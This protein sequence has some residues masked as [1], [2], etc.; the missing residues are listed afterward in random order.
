MQDLSL[1]HQCL[2]AEKA[3]LRVKPSE[4][5][6][7]INQTLM[8]GR[9]LS[10][11]SSSWHWKKKK[12]RAINLSVKPFRLETWSETSVKWNTRHISF[13]H[14]S[15]LW[16]SVGMPPRGVLF[17]STGVTRVWLGGMTLWNFSGSSNGIKTMGAENQQF[18]IG[19]HVAFLRDSF[20]V[21]LL[22]MCVASRKIKQLVFPTHSFF[23]QRSQY[24][25]TN[26]FFLKVLKTRFYFIRKIFFSFL[27]STKQQKR[28]SWQSGF[29][30]FKMCVRFIKCATTTARPEKNQA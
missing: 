17:T 14:L 1:Q 15:L 19:R 13:K 30:Q 18:I 20:I 7:A 9:G 5:S 22:V 10:G 27:H 21:G 26:F 12:K 29:S 25:D 4:G 3:P 24:K 11:W 6:T 2:P 28:K 16:K 23:T 8:F